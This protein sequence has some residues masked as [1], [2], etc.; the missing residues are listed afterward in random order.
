[1][2]YIKLYEEFKNSNSS[3]HKVYLVLNTGSKQKYWSYKGYAGDKFFLQ[4]NEKNI[5]KIDINPN[6]PVL[7]YNSELVERL[8][9][10]KRIKEG[11]IYNLPK[12]A[13]LSSSKEE[14]HKL[15]GEDENIPK[16]VYSK[17][18]A[19]EKLKFPIIAKPSKGH[20][21]IGIKI[22]KKPELLE[23]IDEES[24]DTYS[25]YIDK[26]DEM[27]FFT[28]KGN[29]I[30]WMERKPMNDKAK[31]GKGDANEEMEFHYTKRNVNEIPEDYKKVLEKYSKIYEKL[32]YICFDMMKGK[33]G[34][35]YVIESNSQPGVPFDSTVEIYKSIYQDFYNEKIDKDSLKKLKEYSDKLIQKTLNS[36]TKRFNNKS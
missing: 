32:P 3:L 20:S 11:N 23:E 24:F 27:R 9:K 15:V 28:F 26:I 18:D 6:Y 19:Y 7:N 25:E 8:L 30:F 4:V 16:T 1:M 12:N 13:S 33:N 10:E 22:I 35:I 21:G 36:N 29:P 2:K 17:K 34:H 5:D 14:F 31:S